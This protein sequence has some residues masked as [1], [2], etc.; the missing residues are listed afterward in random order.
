MIV[1]FRPQAAEDVVEA[2]AWYEAHAP[3]LG[4]QLADHS[5]ITVP[6]RGWAGLLKPRP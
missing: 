6:R 4:E 5:V 1:I 3:G 2:A